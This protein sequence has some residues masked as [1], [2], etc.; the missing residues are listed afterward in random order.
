MFSQRWMTRLSAILLAGTLAACGA[1]PAQPLDEV[2]QHRQ[3]WTQQNVA[4]YRYTIENSC[5]CVEEARGPAVVEVNGDK[6]VSVT[7]VATGQPSGD[8]FQQ[9]DTIGDLF[10]IID[11]AKKNGA[12]EVTVTYDEK[13]G[14]P[15]TITIDQDFQ[16]ADEESRYTIS[17]FEVIQ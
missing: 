9:V 7:H 15:L 17:N 14:F 10:T 4:H 3:Q 1:A 11:E 2:A 8:F 13:Y 5:F 12:D 6:T 16:M